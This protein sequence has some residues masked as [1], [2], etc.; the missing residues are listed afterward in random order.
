MSGQ[1]WSSTPYPL[2]EAETSIVSE[3]PWTGVAA[4]ST[5][6]PTT[7][8]GGS[9]PMC[10][11]MSP[12][13]ELS[14]IWGAPAGGACDPKG[15]GGLGV[16]VGLHPPA[17]GLGH[18]CGP[19]QVST[20]SH[21][22]EGMP[23]LQHRVAAGDL[24]T[25][26]DEDLRQVFS[27]LHISPCHSPVNPS[28]PLGSATTPQYQGQAL[29]PTPGLE[30]LSHL[31]PTSVARISSKGVPSKVRARGPMEL[32]SYKRLKARAQSLRLSVHAFQ[33]NLQNRLLN[34][35]RSHQRS[36]PPTCEQ[37]LLSTEAELQPRLQQLSTIR[38][39]IDLHE[40]VYYPRGAGHSVH[41][42]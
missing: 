16:P 38:Q 37:T 36:C 19:A 33:H 41:P 3:G 35:P 5:F 34:H 6:L 31:G 12:G 22:G 24:P 1:T 13:L 27:G 15:P 8:L 42:H 23:L 28:Q 39:A 4:T 21:L 2:P 11:T 30:G 9:E 14:E 18:G 10:W 7:G 20:T 40:G 25:L 17:Y 26:S 29:G 32:T